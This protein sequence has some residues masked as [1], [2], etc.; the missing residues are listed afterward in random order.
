MN[1]GDEVGSLSGSDQKLYAYI[2]NLTVY[3]R[4]SLTDGRE[5]I[6]WCTKVGNRVVQIRYVPD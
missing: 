1:M 6:E 2:A 3:G 4:Q 5:I